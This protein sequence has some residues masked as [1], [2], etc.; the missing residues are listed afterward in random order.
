MKLFFPTFIQ[1]NRLSTQTH[2][3]FDRICSFTKHPLPFMFI[4]LHKHFFFVL[5]RV[6]CL[7]TDYIHHKVNVKTD[8]VW[9]IQQKREKQYWNL[10]K[11][12]RAIIGGSSTKIRDIEMM[13]QRRAF[14]TAFSMESLCLWKR[15]THSIVHKNANEQANDFRAENA[16]SLTEIYETLAIVVQKN[17]CISCKWIILR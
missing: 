13:N 11:I 3:L 4:G 17:I 7:N 12:P 9:Y 1:L 6:F 10:L 16:R 14:A 2:W 5:S 15:M 8:F